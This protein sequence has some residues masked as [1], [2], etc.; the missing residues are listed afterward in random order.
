MHRLCTV[1]IWR[2]SICPPP[3]ESPYEDEC[4]LAGLDE[5]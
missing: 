4:L 3:N 5:S 2:N 1:T